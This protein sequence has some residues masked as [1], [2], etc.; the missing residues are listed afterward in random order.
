MKRLIT[1]VLALLLLVGCG[2]K[3]AVVNAPSAEP[4][5]LPTPTGLP[6]PEPLPTPLISDEWYLNRIQQLLSHVSLYGNCLDQAEVNERVA[7]MYIN[8]NRKMIALTYDGHIYEPYTAQILD[9]LEANNARATFFLDIT[10]FEEQLPTL[11]RMLALG[12]EIGNHS[13]THPK[14]KE[15][16]KSQMREEIAYGV[17]K[18]KSLLDYDITLF[19]PPYGRNNDEVKEVCKEMGL[20]IIMWYRSSHDSHDDYDAAM[21]YDRIMLD[22]DDDGHKLEGST[23]L[24]HMSEA[25]TVEASARFIPDLIAEGYQLVTV[26]E[27]F[28]LSLDGFN[29]GGVYRYK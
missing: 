26:T 15:L 16:T 25:K 29:P 21:I 7:S 10:D 20:K 2:G 12:C 14:F 11:K 19:R 17:E 18:M 23:I 3:A 9:I 24:L 28:M 13:K 1:A 8:P 22:M 5:A 4:T 6:T 27:M